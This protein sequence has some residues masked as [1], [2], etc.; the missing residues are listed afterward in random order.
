ML[1]PELSKLREKILGVVGTTYPHAG[2]EYFGA[3]TVERIERLIDGNFFLVR[4]KEVYSRFL[5]FM[6]K[7]TL[8]RAYGYVVIPSRQDTR[9]VIEGLETAYL[10]APLSAHVVQ[11]F[12]QTFA[13]AAVLTVDDKHYKCKY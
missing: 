5:R 1:D 13:D 8:F 12:K 6:K 11:D 7:N 9:I 3:L 4:D 10:S 2:I